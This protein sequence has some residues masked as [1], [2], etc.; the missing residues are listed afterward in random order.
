[1][2]M[3]PPITRGFPPQ[4]VHVQNPESWNRA[5][6][7]DYW[8]VWGPE[9]IT[10]AAGSSA[11][12]TD[13][14]WTATSLVETAGAA[15]DFIATA[16]RTAPAHVLTD[17]AL[18]LLQSPA[19]FGDY[20]HAQVAAGI[21]GYQPTKLIADFGF[22]FTV[23]TGAEPGSQIGFI[24]AGGSPAVA[25]D[26]MATIASDG[27]NFV[28]RSGAATG[29]VGP[30][31]GAAWRV[32]RIQLDNSV[33]AGTNMVTGNI[34]GVTMPALNLETD[35]FPVSWGFGIVNAGTN[36]IGHSFVHIWY[37]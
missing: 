32:G 15:A 14:G 8:A 19:I 24:E 17:A 35:L 21:L 12:I 4:R 5:G 20:M 18:D 28:L 3:Q 7:T 37:A 11:L 13:S 31:V 36:R 1:M 29:A 10:A 9:V 2:T 34:D 27:T 23:G 26:A 25:N 6:G 33:A 16:D 22:N 30:L